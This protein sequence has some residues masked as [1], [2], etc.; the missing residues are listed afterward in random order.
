MGQQ[1]NSGVIELLL[2]KWRFCN[3]MQSITCSNVIIQ[4]DKCNTNTV[5]LAIPLV[6]DISEA[7]YSKSMLIMYGNN[8]WRLCQTTKVNKSDQL[9]GN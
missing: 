8:H 3:S 9:P 5:H 6:S 4:M 7:S 2:M 1:Q